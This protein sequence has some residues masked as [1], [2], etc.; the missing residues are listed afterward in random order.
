[1]T[2]AYIVPILNSES[3]VRIKPRAKAGWFVGEGGEG[4]REK[5]PSHC[6]QSQINIRSDG[7]T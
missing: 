6:A 2:S 5:E 7:L 4:G 3:E 1:M